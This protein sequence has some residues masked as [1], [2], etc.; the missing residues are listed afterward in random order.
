MSEHKA[1]TIILFNSSDVASQRW[2]ESEC[3]PDGKLSREW[4][5][6]LKDCW[7]T[8]LHFR[9]HSYQCCTQLETFWIMLGSSW[10]WLRSGPR[11]HSFWHISLHN[12]HCKL[13][14]T[15]YTSIPLFAIITSTCTL[16]KINQSQLELTSCSIQSQWTSL[17]KAMAMAKCFPAF[18]RW[19][20]DNVSC[21]T[22]MY[23][24]GQR[25]HRQID[26]S[27]DST[28]QAFICTNWSHDVL[29]TTE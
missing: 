3:F 22:M 2:H 13:R 19:S 26:A 20:Y 5:I 7:H 6:S 18:T 29:N 1:L 12:S 8:H 11:Q 27:A 14:G 10:A 28:T 21:H 4:H 24:Q 15:W 9:L 25:A 16:I 17:A 23:L